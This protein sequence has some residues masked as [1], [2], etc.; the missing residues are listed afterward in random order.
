MTSIWWW[1]SRTTIMGQLNSKIEF[2]ILRN[3]RKKKKRT[4]GRQWGLPATP[5]TGQ[6]EQSGQGGPL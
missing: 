1:S 4:K 6:D 3:R 2:D 5:R